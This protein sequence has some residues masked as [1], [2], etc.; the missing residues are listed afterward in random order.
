MLLFDTPL[1]SG[2]L[3]FAYEVPIYKEL[4]GIVLSDT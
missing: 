3:H 2:V 1:L 4:I